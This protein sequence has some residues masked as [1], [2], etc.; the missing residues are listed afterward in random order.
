MTTQL[1][2]T[3]GIRAALERLQAAL[4]DF[5]LSAAND[6]LAGLAALDMPAEAAAD[7]TRLRDRV[8][9][10]DYDEAQVIVTRIIEQLERTT[11][12]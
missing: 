2:D 10:Y 6:A 9:S 4:G 8:D 1:I 11:Q 7:L 12:P 3:T 5:E